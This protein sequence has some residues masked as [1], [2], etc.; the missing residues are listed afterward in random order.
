MA[1]RVKEAVEY[2]QDLPNMGRP[3]R[4][5]DTKEL[6]ASGHRLLPFTG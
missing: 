4:L 3:G 6:V 5:I 1:A 2:L